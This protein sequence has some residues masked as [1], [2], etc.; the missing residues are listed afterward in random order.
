MLSWVSRLLLV[1]ALLLDSG[2]HLAALQAYAWGAMAVENLKT[3][4]AAEA[5]EAAVDGR[6][7]CHVCMKVQSA[8]KARGQRELR[9][10]DLKADFFFQAPAVAVVSDRELPLAPP[11]AEFPLDRDASPF[12]APPNS[13]LA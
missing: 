11:P 6:H 9:L 13:L 4:A 8:G 1:G 12:V 3:S 7:P 10:P 5:I 2:A